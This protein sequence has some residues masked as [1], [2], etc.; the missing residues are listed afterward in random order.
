M[1]INR[2]MEGF[3]RISRTLAIIGGWPV[4]GLSLLIGV[5]VIGRKLFNLSVQGADEIGGYVMAV[6]CAFGFSFGLAKRSHIRLN[7]VLPKLPP[8]FQ[9]FA[10]VV[11]YLILLAFSY[12]MLW[13]MLDMLF[14]SIRLKAIAP[15]PLQTPLAWPQFLCA[16]GI[17]YFAV[18]LTLYF[19]KAFGLLLRWNI[20]ELNRIFGVETAEKEAE[21]ELKETRIEVR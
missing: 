16:F 13:Q 12:L 9:A 7:I 8:L 11:A 15:T 17:S 6:A 2:L 4:L 1:V 3:D 14:E 10:N 18:H 20:A 5:D 19:I 21:A